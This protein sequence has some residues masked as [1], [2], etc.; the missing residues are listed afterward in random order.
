MDCRLRRCLLAALVFPLLALPA[1]ADEKKPDSGDAC[2]TCHRRQS[3][4]LVMEWERSRHA[5]MDVAC[6]DCHE[7][8]EGEPD[9][10]KHEGAWI[11]ALVTPKD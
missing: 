5:Q 8:K 2:V 6:I 3:P 10:W 1:G 7:A 9:A 4:A 11:S